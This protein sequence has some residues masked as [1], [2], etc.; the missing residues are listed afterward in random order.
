MFVEVEGA[1]ASGRPI[2]RSWHLL[3]EGDDGPLIPSM[4]VEGIVRRLLDGQRPDP[5]A[6]AAVRDLELEDYDRLFA[7]RMI[8]TG[9][10]NDAA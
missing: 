2:T 3:A 1:E 4:A 5:G 9:F 10:R 8:H 7:R 6:R